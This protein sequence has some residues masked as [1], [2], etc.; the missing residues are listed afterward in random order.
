MQV[1]GYDRGKEHR[2][3]AKSMKYRPRVCMRAYVMKI[4]DPWGKV[5]YQLAPVVSVHSRRSERAKKKTMPWESRLCERFL[6]MFHVLKPLP[7]FLS[8][9]MVS[10]EAPLLSRTSLGDC[11]FLLSLSNAH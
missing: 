5:P 1:T 6:P 7:K 4:P 8:S 2:E 3:P 11:V 10:P 9:C